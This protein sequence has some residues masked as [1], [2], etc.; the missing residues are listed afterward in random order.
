MQIPSKNPAHHSQCIARRALIISFLVISLDCLLGHSLIGEWSLKAVGG[1]RSSRV[2]RQNNAMMVD[3]WV[4]RDG[5]ELVSNLIKPNTSIDIAGLPLEIKHLNMASLLRYFHPLNR[6]GAASRWLA[7]WPAISHTF[8]GNGLW[9][10]ST[11]SG[12]GRLGISRYPNAVLS[13]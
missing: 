1:A 3:G 10:I 8:I 13:S 9:L 12:A 5:Y 6:N 2:I 7:G 4:M 11:R